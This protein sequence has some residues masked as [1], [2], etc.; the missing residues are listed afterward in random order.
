MNQATPPTFRASPFTCPHCGVLAQQSWAPMA[1]K[2]QP[3][4]PDIERSKCRN[5]NRHAYWAWEQLVAPAVP[6]GPPPNDDLQGPLLDVYQEA[7]DVAGRSPRAAAALLR[8]L[9]ERLVHELD[10]VGHEGERLQVKVD[11]LRDDGKID[12]GTYEA[13]LAVKIAG[14]GALHTGQIDTEAEDQGEV[15]VVLF[16]IVNHIVTSTRSLHREVEAL[17]QAQRRASSE[18]GRRISEQKR[19]AAEPSDQR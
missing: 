17:R 13:M 16:G 19:K 6:F 18:K 15:V 1:A 3:I 2:N 9:V 8:L 11:R 14:D 5:C 4:D 10:G 7:R 12:A